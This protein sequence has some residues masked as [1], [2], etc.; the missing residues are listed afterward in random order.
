MLYNILVIYIEIRF[1]KST[2]TTVQLLSSE[3]EDI[4]MNNLLIII[5]QIFIE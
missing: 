5:M 4:V 3:H 1:I 2:K